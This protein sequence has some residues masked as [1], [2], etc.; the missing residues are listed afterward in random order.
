MINLAVLH[1][2]GRG[3]WRELALLMEI[4]LKAPSLA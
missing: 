2:S 1:V 3:R 4:S